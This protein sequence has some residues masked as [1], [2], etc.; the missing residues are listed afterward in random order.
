MKIV[1]KFCI[2][3]LPAGGDEQVAEDADVG[4]DEIGR[5]ELWSMRLIGFCDGCIIGGLVGGYLARGR[6]AGS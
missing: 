4:D 6:L 1:P 3:R 5:V 2:L